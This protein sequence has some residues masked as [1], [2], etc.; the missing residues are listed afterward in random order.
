MTTT[1]ADQLRADASALKV[2]TDRAGKER[3]LQILGIVLMVAGIAIAFAA[4][5]S[6][7]N[8]TATPGSNVD[9]LNSNAYGPLGMTGLATSVVGAAVFLRYSL[10]DFFRWWLLRQSYDM[11]AAIEEAARQRSSITL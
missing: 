8:V 11:Q 6:A 9:V 3:G 4:Y 1:R 10:A 7:L 5:R 2:K